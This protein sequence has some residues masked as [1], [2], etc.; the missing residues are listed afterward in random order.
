[1]YSVPAESRPL[2]LR[3]YVPLRR[4]RIQRTEDGHGMGP[5]RLREA[6]ASG[7]ADVLR[8]SGKHSA[9]TQVIRP[10][11]PGIQCRG[12]TRNGSRPSV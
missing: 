11:T 4:P 12:R 10:G 3:L 8:A 5:A 2:P 9:A 7:V 6:A 1:M